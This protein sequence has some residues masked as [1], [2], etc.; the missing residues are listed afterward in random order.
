MCVPRFVCSCELVYARCDCCEA[1]HAHACVCVLMH[2]TY[3]HYAF[4]KA[5]HVCVKVCFLGFYK[6]HA[7]C[8]CLLMLPK[9][10]AVLPCHLGWRTLLKCNKTNH[11]CLL[12]NI[13]YL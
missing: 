13:M 9:S 6:A 5:M 3:S 11:A 1:M 8:D 7:H 10:V 4:C 12:T 2:K